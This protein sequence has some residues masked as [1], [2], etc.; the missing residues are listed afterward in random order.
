L[1][2]IVGSEERDR[3]NQEH[4]KWKG[5]SGIN[6]DILEEDII[7]P[8]SKSRTGTNWANTAA[9]ATPTRFVIQ[10]NPLKP[11]SG[12]LRAFWLILDRMSARTSSTPT[13]QRASAGSRFASRGLIG[14]TRQHDPH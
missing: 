2:K 5:P 7:D 6:E 9:N 14:G 4:V 13:P 12:E 11:S 8:P 10:G 1:R 3:R